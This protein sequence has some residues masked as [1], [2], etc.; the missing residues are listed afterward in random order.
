MDMEEKEGQPAPEVEVLTSDPQE[1]QPDRP[2]QTENVS[3]QE[4]MRVMFEQ[5]SQKMGA[6]SYTHLDVYK[7]QHFET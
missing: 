7:R 1:N 6:V 3:I 4:M 5:L 2:A